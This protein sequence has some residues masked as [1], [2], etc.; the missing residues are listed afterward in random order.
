[1]CQSVLQISHATKQ[2]GKRK[3]QR[4]LLWWNRFQWDKVCVAKLWN[5]FV[6]DSW[7]I[8]VFF[9]WYKIWT[10]GLCIWNR[11]IFMNGR[12]FH[13]GLAN[14]DLKQEEISEW[15]KN[16]NFSI[17]ADANENLSW[18]WNIKKINIIKPWLTFWSNKDVKNLKYS[19]SFQSLPALLRENLL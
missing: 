15:L 19:T 5:E 16:S 4:L 9:S 11:W 8:Y 10:C 12:H 2:Q 13:P 7:I 14:I 6:N 1:M 18:S 3:V 17:E